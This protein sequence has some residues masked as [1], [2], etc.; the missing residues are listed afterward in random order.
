MNDVY[1]KQNISLGP[2]GFSAGGKLQIKETILLIIIFLI[3]ILGSC[4]ILNCALSQKGGD[5]SLNQDVQEIILYTNE[6]NIADESTSLS[7]ID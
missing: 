7:L 1:P 6:L 3:G 2:P 4:Y 5:S